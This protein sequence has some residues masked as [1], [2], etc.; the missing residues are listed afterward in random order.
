GVERG[1]LGPREADRIWERHLL[2]CAAAAIL[3]P[4][5]CR[6]LDVGSGAGL[7]GIPLALARP[8]VH[9]TLLDSSLR[10]T[11]FL[12]EAVALLGLNEQAE[13]QR[14]RV[15]EWRAE[16]PFAV[17]VARAVAPLSRLLGWVRPALAASGLV[18]V[19]V[20]DRD[21]RAV[22]GGV[23]PHGWR[24]DLVICGQGMADPPTTVARMRRA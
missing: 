8:D 18:L 23:V 7:P 22:A 3:L 10:R 1:L 21:A 9:V 14:A 12:R 11:T 13:V 16:P 24:G 2:N 5:G 6:V 19:F 4:A 20:G 15:E 17:V